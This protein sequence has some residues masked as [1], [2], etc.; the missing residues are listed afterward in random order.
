VGAL[1]LVG[2]A[3]WSFAVAVAGGAVGLVLG[4]LRLPLFLLAASSPAAAGGANIAVSGISAAT[5]STTHVRAGRINWRLFGWMA[6]PSVAGAL[7]G[8]YLAGVVPDT[9]VLLAIAA[10]LLYSGLDLLLRT[11][12][13]VRTRERPRV[14]AA[15]VS[16]AVIGLLGGFVGLILGSLRMPALLRVVGEPPSR[17]VGTNLAVGVLVG[18]AGLIGHLPSA[19][20]DWRLIAVGG[21]ASIPGA[22]LG[23]RLTGRLSD[24]ALVQAIGAVLLV[25]GTAA[26]IQAF[27]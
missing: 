13:A 1:E 20:P 23:A 27:V 5:A 21:A 14:L 2:I 25:A 26:G 4:N 9:A 24:R 18:I 6:P 3:A 19:A 17:A 22:L 11:E 16:G 8:G 10:V 15:V 7:A 12:A